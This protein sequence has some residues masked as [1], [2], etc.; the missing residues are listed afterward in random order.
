M[1]TG[2]GAG[3]GSSRFHELES[4]LGQ[5]VK[6]FG[7]LSKIH[8]FQV[9]GS[10]IA[11]W[12]LAV[13]QSSGGKKNCI[14][15][16]LVCIFIIIIIIIAISSRSISIVSSISFVI[17]LNCLYLNPQALPFVHFSSPSH[18]GVNGAGVGAVSEQLSSA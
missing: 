10:V 6:L 13:N 18:W 16:R 15:Y 9:P 8:D 3:I 4:S 5:E 7:E 1:G 12:G 14:V 2:Q 17:L 11:A